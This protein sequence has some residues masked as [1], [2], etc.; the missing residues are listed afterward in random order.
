MRKV[1]VITF[2]ILLIN[3]LCEFEKGIE[4]QSTQAYS[5]VCSEKL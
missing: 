4:F 5:D 1:P 3:T 2:F